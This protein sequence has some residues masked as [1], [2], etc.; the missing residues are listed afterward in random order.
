LGEFIFCHATSFSS[1]QQLKHFAM[2]DTEPSRPCVSKED[3]SLLSPEER[4][5]FLKF[6]RLKKQYPFF[7]PKRPKYYDSA[8]HA[9][10]QMRKFPKQ[11]SQTNLTEQQESHS[12][13]EEQHQ[14]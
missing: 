13:T 3:L 12:K 10:E 6:G 7:N 9:L 8:D 11:K 4:A 1:R 2:N 14:T 5:F